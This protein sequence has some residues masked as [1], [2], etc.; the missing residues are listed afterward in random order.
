MRKIRLCTAILLAFGVGTVTT[1]A[2]AQ[3]SL[4]RVEITGSAIKRVDAETAVPITILRVED[5]KKEGVTTVE[6]LVQRLSGMQQQQ[7]TSQVVGLGTAGASFAD[8]RGLGANKTLVLLNGRRIANNAFDSST[9]DLNTIPFAALERVEILRD[10]ASSLYGTDAIGGV[11]NFITRKDFRG[12]TV[13][14]GSDITEKGG[15]RTKLGN[16][17]AGFGDLSSDRFN[18]LAFLDYNHQNNISGTERD[19]NLRNLRPSPTPFPGNYFQTGNSYNPLGPACANSFLLQD[20]TMTGCQFIP[21]KFVDYVPRSERISGFLGGALALGDAHTLRLEYFG[22]R[23]QVDAR[24]A[25]VPFGNLTVDPGTP[26]YPGN[27]ITPAPPA[28]SGID[29]TMPIH[30]RFRD[31]PNGGRMGDDHNYQQRFVASLEGTAASWDYQTALTYNTNKVHSNL[32]GG[33]ADGGIITPGVKSGVINPFGDQTAAGAALL[34]SALTTG[35]LLNGIGTVYGA[36]ARASRELGDWFRAS[37]PAALAVGVEARRES[38]KQTANA[39]F[40]ARVI[41]STGTDPA[42]DNEGK[43]T[44][45]AGYVELNVPLLKSLEVTAAVRYDKYSDFGSTTNPKVSF[46]F[47]PLQQLLLRGSVST[48]FRAPSLFELNSAQ[49][50]TNTAAT[51]DDPVLCPG[52]KPNPGVSAA[53]A[54]G[55]QFIELNGGNKNLK[56]E[57]SNSATLGLVFEPY[58]GTSFSVDYWTIILRQ[59]IGGA[60]LPDATIFGDPLKYAGLF[61]RAPDGTLSTDGSECPGA[62]CGFIFNP[63]QNFGKLSTNGVDLNASYRL[64]T[65]AAGNFTFSLNSTY[66]HKYVYQNEEGGQYFQ[67]V[68]IY[69]GIGPIFKWQHSLTTNWAFGPWGAGIAGRYKSGYLDQNPPNQVGTYTV[70]DVYGS[71]Q[72]LKSLQLTVGVKNVFDRGPPFSNQTTTFAV[73]YDPRFAEVIG[74]AYYFRGT[75]NF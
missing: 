28:G 31:V 69:S 22:T 16:V 53:V 64:R 4:D 54:C 67:N 18:V 51:W 17:G 24:I 75:Y 65:L 73:G 5:L 21:G 60:G 26:F 20:A 50:F 55:Q 14:I 6:Q 8:L 49:T 40:A 46:R 1:R 9:P 45:V 2:I 44:V 52:G 3:Q 42:T 36:D 11:I 43:R 32:S 12:G 71:W 48:G 23:T 41:A 7:A 66:V 27:G 25:P 56:P 57:K 15:G 13:T 34:A 30:V 61:H 58:A 70:F 62:A 10:G 35:N 19:F 74:R 39:D 38:F 63:A 29:P 59:Q 37:R 33:Y 47:T 68:G 72:A